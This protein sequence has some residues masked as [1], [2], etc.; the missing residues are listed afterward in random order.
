MVYVGE[1][2]G[3]VLASPDIDFVH[4]ID[5]KEEARELQGTEGLNLV[6]FYLLPHYNDRPFEEVTLKTEQEYGDK[7]DLLKIDNNQAVIIG[8]DGQ[9]KILG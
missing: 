9:M 1:S 3:A 7:L 6:D 5:S 8:A 4:M 2:A